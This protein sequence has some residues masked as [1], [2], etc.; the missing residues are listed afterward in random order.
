MAHEQHGKGGGDSATK[1]SAA[2][3]AVVVAEAAAT[4]TRRRPSSSSSHSKTTSS[5]RTTPTKASSPPSHTGAAVAV[6]A[7]ISRPLDVLFPE[8]LSPPQLDFNHSHNTHHPLSSGTG[9]GSNEG[10]DDVFRLEDYG[11]V[12]GGVGGM[13]RTPP[14][15]ALYPSSGG[16]LQQQH[17]REH[18]L[19]PAAVELFR[20]PPPPQTTVS[21]S[22]SADSATEKGS[23]AKLPHGLTVYEL[24]EMT[25]ARLEAEAVHSWGAPS[26]SSSTSVILMKS[27]SNTTA[28]RSAAPLQYGRGGGT[29]SPFP[30]PTDG[31]ASV[32]TA[33]SEFYPESLYSN[34]GG[35]GC[36][37]NNNHTIG[38]NGSTFV[39]GG[40]DETI[41]FS[42][43][44]SYPTNNNPNS[45]N[46]TMNDW[47]SSQLPHE[48]ATHRH[49][50][51][52][53]HNPPLFVATPP[54]PGNGGGFYDADTA[55]AAGFVPNRRRA[56][57]LSPRLGLSYVLHEDH[58]TAT[59]HHLGAR[60][61]P[62]SSSLHPHPEEQQHQQRRL[63]VPE[64]LNFGRPP[65][66][67]QMT[68]N[69]VFGFGT[70]NAF[71]MHQNRPRTASMP[72]ISHTDDEEFFL[73]N[74]HRGG[75]MTA[76]HNSSIT[77][78][79]FGSHQFG[80]VFEDDLPSAAGLV[81]GL[82]DVFRGPSP[83]SNSINHLN[84]SSATSIFGF[85]SMT[86]SSTG[87]GSS[88]NS[89]GGGG[90][91]VI[92]MRA[93]TSSCDYIG[94]LGGGES[95][96]FCSN[97]NN[98]NGHLDDGRHRAATWSESTALDL[99]CGHDL[100]EDLASILK[101]SGAE[102]KDHLS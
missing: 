41:P 5:R 56:A 50:N 87:L 84:E 69:T 7:N 61:S 62:R 32:S 31:S 68:N 40:G 26:S 28:N 78:R 10:F 37:N 13:I 35:G 99:F 94:G 29:R 95:L 79:L 24:K 46:N 20:T 75:G 47:S 16:T 73:D 77:P 54:P 92:R 12:G 57:T 2:A 102:Q 72:A 64:A 59:D 80:S 63:V 81:A 8:H 34:K 48:R 44:A 11:N 98:A 6:A 55:A 4:P 39:S 82:S 89:F 58:A 76:T 1:S 30:D 51:H 19:E 3:V 49:P 91:D 22:L 45:N 23:N 97:G 71:E 101:L 27:S 60:F 15:H 88:M 93:A 86:N 21:A 100:S 14:P 33:T 66:Y 53:H 90:G 18:H 74:H 52:P 85:G 42:R 38:N 9:S 83:S 67:S 17:Q 96:S 70:G 36:L 65:G 25:K 43:S